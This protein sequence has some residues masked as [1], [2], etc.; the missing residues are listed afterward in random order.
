MITNS[1]QEEEKTESTEKPP[2]IPSLNVQKKA[3]EI[4]Y[5]ELERIR[6]KRYEEGAASLTEEEKEILSFS[7]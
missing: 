5:V 1:N 6:D 4:D 3:K 2:P 7:Q